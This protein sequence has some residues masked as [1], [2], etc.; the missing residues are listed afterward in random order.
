MS[1]T[2][3]RAGILFLFLI[4]SVC[5]PVSAQPLPGKA[6]LASLQEG[7]AIVQAAWELRHGFIPKPDCSHFVHAVYA[8]AGFPYEYAASKEIFSGTDRFQRVRK[9]QPGDLIVWQGHIGIVIDPREH[10]F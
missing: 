9:A 10:T 2:L 4:S 8:Q 3:S 6:R 1:G 7:E 5:C